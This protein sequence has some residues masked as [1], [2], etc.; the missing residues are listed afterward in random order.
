MTSS[1]CTQKLLEIEIEMLVLQKTGNLCRMNPNRGGGG[2]SRPV[3]A[4]GIHRVEK[5]EGN[6]VFF[7]SHFCE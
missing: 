7:S 3:T 6:C 5:M 4:K 1:G 2:S